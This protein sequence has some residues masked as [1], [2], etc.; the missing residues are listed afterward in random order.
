MK[1]CARAVNFIQIINAEGDVR[2]CGWNRNNIIG[3]ILEQDFSEVLHSAKADRLRQAM[4]A[5]D[6]SNCDVD[7]CPYLANNRMENILIDIENIPDYPTE[8]YLAYEGIC[9]YQCT[10][11]TS[12][13]HMEDTRKNDYSENYDL[14]E[15]RL[16]KVLPY[17]RRISA[18]GRGELFASKRILKL[19]QTWKPV[20]PVEEV[21]VFLETN[22]SMF[23][24]KHWKQIENLGQYHLSVAITVMSFDEMVY[25]HLSGTRLPVSRI[26]D[27]LKFVRKLREEGII[28]YLELAT[29]LQEENFREMPEFTRR[30]IEEFG[31]DVVRIRPIRPGGIYDR[32]IQWFMDVRN[33]KHPY[34]SQYREVMGHPVFQNPKVLLWSGDIPS[35]LGD[36]PGAKAE[37]IQKAADAMLSGFKLSD[38]LAKRGM[39]KDDMYLYGIGTLGKLVIRL[40]EEKIKG[41][42]DKFSSR[43]EWRG[44]PVLKLKDAIGK[45][46]IVVV[47]TYGSFED[48]KKEL[49]LSGFSGEIV[50]LF[51]LLKEEK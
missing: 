2:V 18:N 25:R 42:Y 47:T 4:A 37:A 46:G 43:K 28:N 48:I 41:V 15:E 16:K 6:Y 44:V 5:G 26:E 30:C 45:N 40:N 21:S 9:N 27:N 38:C 29:V 31:A 7:N 50:S 33:P 10:C 3:N 11:C 23:D 20:A 34:Y 22:G 14:L 51:D 32:A 19:L 17:V 24:E 12:F 36:Y 1:I 13:Q 35:S 49:S 39:E 8:L